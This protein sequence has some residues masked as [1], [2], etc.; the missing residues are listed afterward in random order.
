MKK[1]PTI[2]ALL[3]ANTLYPAPVRD[4]LLHLADVGLFFPK[5]T[6]QIHDEW[7][8]N[9]LL[10]RPELQLK[11]LNAAKR[12]MNS[13]FPDADVKN[14]HSLIEKIQLP[15]ADDRHILAAAIH[16]KA[17]FIITA[18]LKHFPQ[19]YMATFFIQA[20]H[21]DNFVAQL[22]HQNS[23]VVLRAFNKQVANLKHPPMTREEVLHGLE[24]CGLKKTVGLLRSAG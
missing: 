11:N 2:T 19:K 22:F 6:E 20:F 7:M 21:P 14:F 16:A 4:L 9:L 23:D 3:D 18:N 12:A 17:D 13:A 5:W 1:E 15:D 8:R 24:K 10:N